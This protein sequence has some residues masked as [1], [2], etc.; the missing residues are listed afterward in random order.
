MR[1]DARR[2][3]GAL[4][5]CLLIVL[6]GGQAFA[7][8]KPEER[9]LEIDEGEQTALSALG[10]E[11]YSVGREGI[12]DVRPAKDGSQFVL[13]GQSPGTTTLLFIMSRS[14]KRVQY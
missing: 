5:A 14:G 4:A 13:V 12:V 1:K 3:A 8:E 6:A 7:E 10:V 2:L 9:R 11:Q